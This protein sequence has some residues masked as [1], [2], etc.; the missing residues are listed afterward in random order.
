MKQTV[1]GALQSCWVEAVAS[2]AQTCQQRFN[3]K[4]AFDFASICKFLYYADLFF[5]SSL[6]ALNGHVLASE[7]CHFKGICSK[8]FF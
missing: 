6:C 3:L 7:M 1:C 8:G 2:D 4:M 5:F